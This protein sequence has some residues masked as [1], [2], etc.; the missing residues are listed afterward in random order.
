MKWIENIWRSLWRGT[1]LLGFIEPLYTLESW[2][3]ISKY[4]DDPIVLISLSLSTTAAI[5]PASST[6][7]SAN[8][9][10]TWLVLLPRT[11][12]VQKM[13]M[14]LL[15]IYPEFFNIFFLYCLHAL[16][17]LWTS[18]HRPYKQQMCHGALH[19]SS[20]DKGKRT[21]GILMVKN[22][23]LDLIVMV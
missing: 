10:S 23:L 7:W 17:M 21:P 16:E 14:V 11:P 19:R 12:M 9:T 6:Y 5:R 4:P 3:I 22:S 13:L 1:V 8:C 20:C 2:I 18:V 15:S